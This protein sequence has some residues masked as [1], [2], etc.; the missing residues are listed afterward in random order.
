MAL[1]GR[2]LLFEGRLCM[3]YKQYKLTLRR[4]VIGYCA[5]R[6][7][8][9]G[10]MSALAALGVTRR[11]ARGQLGLN[12]IEENEMCVILLISINIFRYTKLGGDYG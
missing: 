12:H 5:A 11:E 6:Q 7:I 2:I 10:A 9:R 1:R 4:R 3:E 8:D